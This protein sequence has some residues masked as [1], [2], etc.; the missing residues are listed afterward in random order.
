MSRYK[1][2]DLEAAKAAI[3]AE[4]L[5]Y[6]DAADAFLKKYG[7]R[8]FIKYEERQN[9]WSQPKKVVSISLAHFDAL[10]AVES[11]DSRWFQH[12]VARI[13]K[14]VTPIGMCGQEHATLMID[15]EG[16]VYGGYDECFGKI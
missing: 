4:G 9:G 2:F 5:P 3:L 6:L 11:I 12:Y 16:V 15:E 10:R 14:L 8:H 13:D 1:P 7:G